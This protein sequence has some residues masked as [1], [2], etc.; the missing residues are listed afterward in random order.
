MLGHL[1]LVCSGAGM[2]TSKWFVL[3]EVGRLISVNTSYVTEVREPSGCQGI[4]V[5]THGQFFDTETRRTTN[6]YNKVTNSNPRG[7]DFREEFASYQV[8]FSNTS[9]L[10]TQNSV[11]TGCFQPKFSQT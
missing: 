3:G 2:L 7:T 5:R 6:E 10:H 11:G 1:G 4:A 8:P 9:S